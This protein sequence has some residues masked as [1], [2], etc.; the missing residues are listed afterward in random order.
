MLNTASLPSEDEFVLEWVPTLEQAGVIKESN[1][2]RWYNDV[3]E[4]EPDR[5]KWHFERLKGW[6]GSD[7]GEVA[8]SYLEKENMFST[9]REIGEHKLMMRSPEGQ[10]PHMRRGTYLEDSLGKIFRE[11]YS[12]TRLPE[13]ID[14]I[15]NGTDDNHRW[16]R[17]NTDDVVS[18]ASAHTLIV[19]YKCAAHPK[20]SPPIQYMA[21]VH[22]Y[23]HLLKNSPSVL[24]EGDIDMAIVYLDYE[25]G[26]SKPITV[27]YDQEVMD[28][29]LEGG[30]AAWELVVKGD[31][32]GLSDFRKPMTEDIPYEFSEEEL[33]DIAVLE[34]EWSTAH[35]LS[36]AADERLEVTG[37]AFTDALRSKGPVHGFKGLPVGSATPTIRQNFDKAMVNELVELK[38][39]DPANFMNKG[40]KYDADKMATHLLSL[41]VNLEQFVE[42][43][44]D[45]NKL[46]EE[47]KEKGINKENVVGETLSVGLR[48]TKKSGISK[49]DFDH[50][51][52]V[53]LEVVLKAEQELHNYSPELPEAEHINDGEAQSYP[54]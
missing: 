48:P 18:I 33:Q 27:P 52:T 10:T 32:P 40:P 20:E 35:M 46:K 34:G 29:V 12:A 43:K 30:D 53:A 5:F 6:G 21:Q 28:A 39:I 41:D 47:L 2:R 8:A 31:L 7:I 54:S 23:H 3:L 45:I 49:E 16:L 37:K 9:V 50:A 11:D 42:E 15:D 14:A 26:L 13:C 44:L 24:I 17:G 4:I 22:Q 1:A 25:A 36:K 19:D 38:S 51:K